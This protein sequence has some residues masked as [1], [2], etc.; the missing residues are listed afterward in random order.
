M[1]A[2]LPEPPEPWPAD[3][4]VRHSPGHAKR[5]GRLRP[6]FRLAARWQDAARRTGERIRFLTDPAD[7]VRGRYA[8]CVDLPDVEELHL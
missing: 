5:D 7:A 8:I 6:A 2:D 1:I 4:A 3:P